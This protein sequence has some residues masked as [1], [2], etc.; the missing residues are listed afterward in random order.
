MKFCIHDFHYDIVLFDSERKLTLR[1]LAIAQN[2]EKLLHKENVEVAERTV[3]VVGNQNSVRRWSRHI[4][5]QE[6]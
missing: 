1:D 6:C 5:Y 3:L 2:R 4:T